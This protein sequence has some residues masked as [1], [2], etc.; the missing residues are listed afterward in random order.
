MVF[1][2]LSFLFPGIIGDDEDGDDVDV[3]RLWETIRGN[4][5]DGGAA[6]WKKVHLYLARRESRELCHELRL[7]SLC[8]AH[9]QPKKK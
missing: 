2:A 7:V 1:H 6:E 9:S 5:P 3:A 8:V 4:G